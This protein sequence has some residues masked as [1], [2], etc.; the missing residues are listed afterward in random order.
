MVRGLDV[1]RDHFS[2]FDDHY[3]LIGGA[4]CSIAMEDARL[5]FRATKDLDIVLCIEALD[6]DFVRLFWDFIRAGNYK[7][8]QIST[9]RKLFYRFFDPG[10]IRYPYMLELFSRAP[11]VLQLHDDSH[12]TPIPVNEDVSSLS[13]ILLDDDYYHFVHEGKTRRNGIASLG[14]EHLIPLKA[15]AWLDL[16]Q[17]KAAGFKV[18][19]RDIRKHRNDVFRLF[20]ILDP[21]TEMILPDSVWNDMLRFL[22]DMEQ[23]RSLPLRELGLRNTTSEQVIED[24]KRI[25]GL[26]H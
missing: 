23:E 6:G 17:R 12:L 7:N 13:A 4:A 9:E 19:G 15:R 25:Y 8:R 21:E 10:D 26:F 24:L 18:D 20:Q 22:S 2:G 3:V 14:P 5:E 11:D 1:F 16:V